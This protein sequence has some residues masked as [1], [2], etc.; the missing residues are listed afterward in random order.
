MAPVIQDSNNLPD[1]NSP[2]LHLS[3]PTPAECVKIWTNTSTSWRDSLPLQVYLEESLYLTTVPLAKDNGMTTWI[4]VDRNLP[5]DERPILCS[6]ESFRKRSLTSDAY[7]NVEDSIVHGI[8]SVFCPPEYRRRGYAARHM[9]EMAKVLHT[10]QLEQSRCVGSILY[11]DIGK[12]YYANL[13][14]QP[15][16]ENNHI[17]FPPL[18]IPKPSI[19][20]E[21]TESDL[22]RFCKKDEEMIRAAMSRPANAQRRLTIVP[23]LN[24]ML[25]HIRKED[26]ATKYLFGK[27][28]QAKGAI[29]GV[30]GMRIWAIWT[31]RY[32]A[33]PNSESP[34]N[35]LYILRVGMEDDPEVNK[36]FIRVEE[37]RDYIEKQMRYFKAVIEAAQAQAAEWQLDHVQLWDPS[38]R[39]QDLIGLS[40][41]EHSFVEREEESIASGLWYDQDG[42]VNSPP[43]WLNNEHYAWL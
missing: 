17:V 27:S 1:S 35:I 11:S 12:T 15:N 3:H 6:C 43:L 36:P 33:R 34:N 4:L 24:H 5:P 20:K 14:W 30:V 18:N 38:D 23:D 41:M 31:H 40:E 28:P 37:G 13:G 9:K 42:D 16:V 29:A 7:G 39:I 21:L 19:A 10:W 8:A 2:D 26:F 22:A 32:Y 25:W